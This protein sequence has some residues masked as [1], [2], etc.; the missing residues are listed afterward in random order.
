[1]GTAHFFVILVLGQPFFRLVSL[2]VSE[3]LE[4]DIQ[5]EFIQKAQLGRFF[6]KGWFFREIFCFGFSWDLHG[7]LVVT[8]T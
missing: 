7:W 3:E 1:M 5:K 4:L 8:G 6:K 2:D